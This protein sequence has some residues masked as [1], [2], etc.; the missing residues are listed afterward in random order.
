MGSEFCTPGAAST[1]ASTAR[2]ERR[3][4]EYI[5]V[6]VYPPAPIPTGMDV[7]IYSRMVG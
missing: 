3:S 2:D 7:Y 5:M 4:K 1:G 6:D